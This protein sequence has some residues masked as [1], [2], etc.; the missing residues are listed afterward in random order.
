MLKR[1]H[2]WVGIVGLVLFVLSGQYFQHS[3]NALQDLEDVPRLLLRTS[4]VYFFFAC[5]IN[6]T[7]GLYYPDDR[8]ATWY[9]SANQLLILLVPFLLAYGFVY[10]AHGNPGIERNVSFLANVLAF[11]WVVNAVLISLFSRFRAARRAAS[12]ESGVNE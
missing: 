6:V 4:H 5:A 9:E 3:L 12:R 10:E 7:L 1:V 8:R 11:V 2:F